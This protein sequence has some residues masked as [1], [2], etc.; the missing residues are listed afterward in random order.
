MGEYN[1]QNWILKKFPKEVVKIIWNAD[2][3]ALNLPL[4]PELVGIS[5]NSSDSYTQ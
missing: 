1:N 4:F 3:T 5:K 2:N